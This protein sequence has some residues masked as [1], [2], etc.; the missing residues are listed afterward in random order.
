MSSAGQ[1]WSS[2]QIA[3]TALACTQKN[4]PAKWTENKA[5]LCLV[6]WGRGS[7][8]QTPKRWITSI[9]NKSCG[10]FF[11][12]S[13]ITWYTVIVL[14]VC[15]FC[16]DVLQKMKSDACTGR[17]YWCWPDPVCNIC[18]TRLLWYWASYIFVKKDHFPLFSSR[19][20]CTFRSPYKK[21]PLKH[22]RQEILNSVHHNKRLLFLLLVSSRLHCGMGPWF[23]ICFKNQI[24]Q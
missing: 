16:L 6:L 17:T 21:R 20:F 19:C 3:D 13:D 23:R 18:I 12:H 24:H 11:S 9:P 5:S 15:M 4:S 8:K 10:S 22:D 1:T 14:T 7:H 2:L